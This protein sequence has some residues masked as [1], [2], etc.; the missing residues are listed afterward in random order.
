MKG[1]KQF[2]HYNTSKVTTGCDF[3]SSEANT[4]KNTVISPNFVQFPY[5]STVSAE[6]VPLHKISI[7]GN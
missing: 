4:A 6:T 3:F 1:L 5:S 2:S 7:L